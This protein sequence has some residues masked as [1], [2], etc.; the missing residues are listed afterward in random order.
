[1]NFNIM[2]KPFNEKETDIIKWIISMQKGKYLPI[3]F[4][5]KNGFSEDFPETTEFYID[6][7]RN[8]IKLRDLPSQKP[9]ILKKFIQNNLEHY[10]VW[11]MFSEETIDR[12]ENEIS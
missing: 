12:V 10:S 1:M 11:Y 6:G 9:K 5:I 3:D 4:T 8:K 7:S 2:N